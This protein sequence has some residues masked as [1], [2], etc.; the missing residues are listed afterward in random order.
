MINDLT[1]IK[2]LASEFAQ[3]YKQSLVADNKLASGSLTKNIKSRVKYDGK[4]LEI[5][6]S[7]EDYWKYVEY[8]RK[9]GKFPPIDKIRNWILIKPILPRPLSNGKLPTTNQLAYLISR[10]IATKGIKPTYALRDS[11][12]KFDLVGRL[13]TII[14]NEIQKQILEN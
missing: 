4:W 3:A 9:P 11:I 6:L 14:G 12:T 2:Q 7:L 10:K 8:G 1:Q 5:I 13:T